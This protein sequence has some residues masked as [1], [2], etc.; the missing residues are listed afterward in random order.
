MEELERAISSWEKSVISARSHDFKNAA[1]MLERGEVTVAHR[2]DT[3]LISMAARQDSLRHELELVVRARLRMFSL[4]A[5]D[6]ARGAQWLA[7]EPVRYE[8]HR[9][10][11]AFIRVLSPAPFFLFP[12]TALTFVIG[13]PIAGALLGAFAVTALVV[14]AWHVGWSD[15]VLTDR[16]ML[17]DGRTI[18]LEGVTRVVFVKQLH[19]QWPA[20]LRIQFWS[21]RRLL[22]QAPIRHAPD[23]L[24]AAFRR[25]GRE[26]DFALSFS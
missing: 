12:L 25:I 13:G 23:E 10:T 7:T 19:R 22:E 26:V 9:L 11:F 1:E 21:K 16:R 5:I 3:G 18:D 15:V 24:R 8:H 6:L 4:P 2:G 20:S 14:A 17:V